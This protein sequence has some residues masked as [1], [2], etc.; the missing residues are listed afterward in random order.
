MYTCLQCTG[1]GI[2]HSK[3]LPA[4][5]KATSNHPVPPTSDHSPA[6]LL[7][8]WWCHEGVC[9]CTARA[10][11]LPCLLGKGNVSVCTLYTGTVH[12]DQL[13]HNSEE[14]QEEKEEVVEE[15][16]EEEVVE[17]DGEEEEAMVE[18][19]EE[20]AQSQGLTM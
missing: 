9:T 1:N 3:G 10:G 13:W 6:I 12:I 8:Y 20:R 11:T 7:Q 5:C 18:E 2:H 19:Q 4:C 14:E 15:E 17:E 16:E